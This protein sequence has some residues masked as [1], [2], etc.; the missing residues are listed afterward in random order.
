M[1]PT[2]EWDHYLLKGVHNFGIWANIYKKLLEGDERR[3]KKSNMHQLTIF[4]YQYNTFSVK[5][6]M[7]HSDAKPLGRYKVDLLN[8]W[9][10]Y[11]KFQ[12]Y[13]VL[14]SY[15]IATCSSVHQDTYAHLSNVYKVEN[16]FGVYNTS[17][18]VL[19]YEEYWSIYEG[20]QILS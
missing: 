6:T 14:C 11:E 7:D 18:Q 9:C 15:V 8:C 17:F 16:L 12:A 1:Q 5:E 10:D 3:T 20:D 19:T 4:D 13:H 2:I